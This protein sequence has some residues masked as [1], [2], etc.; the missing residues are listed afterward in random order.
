MMKYEKIVEINNNWVIVPIVLGYEV[1]LE[2]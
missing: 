2:F 1:I